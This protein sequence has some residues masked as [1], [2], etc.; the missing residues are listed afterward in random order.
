MDVLTS[1]TCWALNNEIIKQVTSSWSLFIQLS[2]KEFWQNLSNMGLYIHKLHRFLCEEIG[3]SVRMLTTEIRL[4]A[5]RDRRPT[6]NIFLYVSVRLKTF[7]EGNCWACEYDGCAW[8]TGWFCSRLVS[9]VGWGVKYCWKM[10]SSNFSFRNNFII[11]LRV[12]FFFRQ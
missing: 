2:L 7:A 12:A 10:Y 5:V 8:D 3:A 1:E 4:Q 6:I 11:F 9:G